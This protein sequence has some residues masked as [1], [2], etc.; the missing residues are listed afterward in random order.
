MLLLWLI[1][2]MSVY[3]CT[4][5]NFNKKSVYVKKIWTISNND[6]LLFSD[7]SMRLYFVVDLLDGNP[8]IH[9]V[10]KV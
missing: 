8:L 2:L 10:L 5:Q 6:K 9:V 4:F 7:S 3:S 1:Y